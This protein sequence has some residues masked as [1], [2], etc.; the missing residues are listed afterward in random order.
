MTPVT[1][2]LNVDFSPS[3]VS[4]EGAKRLSSRQPADATLEAARFEAAAQTQSG[5]C[6]GW[7]GP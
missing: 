2:P 5:D 7:A 4:E 3:F 1:A 6:V